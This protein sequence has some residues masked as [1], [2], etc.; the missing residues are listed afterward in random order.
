MQ[1]LTD[2]FELQQKIYDFFGYREDWRVIPLIDRRECYWA[3]GEEAVLFAEKPLTHD[4]I[5]LGNYYKDCIYRQRF[6]PKYV[7]EADGFTMIS[8]DTHTDG[9]KF[10]AV[11]SNDR[12]QRE[13]E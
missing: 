5:A 9:N 13:F 3:L 1:L 11:Y 8:V 12:R 4:L 2:Y 7:Y 10:L 6:L